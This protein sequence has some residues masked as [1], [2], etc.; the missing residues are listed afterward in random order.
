MGVPKKTIGTGAWT[1][2]NCRKMPENIDILRDLIVRLCDKVNK[3]E[4]VVLSLP[5]NTSCNTNSST[6]TCGNNKT[7]VS[8]GTS[9]EPIHYDL[10]DLSTCMQPENTSATVSYLNEMLDDMLR[11]IT[12]RSINNICFRWTYV[13]GQH[14][15]LVC[16]PMTHFIVIYCVFYMI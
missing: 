8:I 16:S 11:H 1:C 4:S 13:S 2:K 6:Q 5:E 12:F 15:F 9:N 14:T 10:I 3:L 7:L